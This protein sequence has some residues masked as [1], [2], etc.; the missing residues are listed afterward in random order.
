MRILLLGADG[1]VGRHIA[2]R[3]RAQGH[4]IV[5]S[6]RRPARLAQMGFEILP[7]DLTD[8]T[9]RKPAFWQ[10]HLQNIDAIINAAGLLTGTEATFEAVH[11]S[12]PNALYAAKP[13][14]CQI[15][16][17]SAVGIDD[18]ETYF[19]R[20][21]RSAENLAAAHNALILR[22][23][24]ILGETSYGG[25]SL[26]RAL[27]ALPVLTPH[28]GTGD[29]RFNPIHADDLADAMIDMLTAGRTG[30]YDIGGPDRISQREL[31][32]AYRRWLGLGKTWA[33]PIPMPVAR[34]M[35]R[36]GDAMRLGPI[37]RTA[38]AQLSNGVEA[39]AAPLS[40][41]LPRPPRGV[42]D[43]LGRR[44]AGTQDLWHAR[45]YW[46]RPLLRITLAVIWLASALLGLLLPADAFVP[47]LEGALPDGMLI[48]MA[49]VG[50]AAD[51][52]IGLA[53]LRGW[54]PRRLAAIQAAMVI[55][56][57]TLFTF[58]SPVLWL[59]PLGGLLKNLPLLALIAC[60]YI[61]ED[62]R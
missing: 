29:Q 60:L 11:I 25:S 27:A 40:A 35:G 17:L 45:L 14:T 12:A 43:F 41:S 50:G 36:I 58:L 59:L 44:P 61:L 5:A 3:L 8:R 30:T 18:S 57:T 51:L 9:A 55:V 33:I 56:Y 19:S 53:L 39:D 26:V 10:P 34:G 20:F 13:S 32:A 47:I 1:F 48:A 42:H 22:A 16:L 2:F 7:C 15:L 21:R 6:A 23:G 4:D 54:R 24:L 31:T 49:R 46:M 62:E 37:S 52:V 28:I 38:V